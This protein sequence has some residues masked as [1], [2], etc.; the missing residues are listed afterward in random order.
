MHVC[1]Y[2]PY[3]FFFFFL[4]NVFYKTKI[5]YRIFFISYTSFS[6][7]ALLILWC[8]YWIT[9]IHKSRV[10]LFNSFLTLLPWMGQ[11]FF[12][13]LLTRSYGPVFTF[14]FWALAGKASN[15]NRAWWPIVLHVTSD[16]TLPTTSN[17]IPRVLKLL[18]ASL[19]WLCAI[20]QLRVLT[21]NVKHLLFIT[22]VTV[23]F[24]LS[25]YFKG[26]KELSVHRTFSFTEGLRQ[27]LVPTHQSAPRTEAASSSQ[28][29]S[30]WRH[31]RILTEPKS[32]LWLYGLR[33]YNCVSQMPFFQCKHTAAVLDCSFFF[34]PQPAVAWG[35]QNLLY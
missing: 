10:F 11:V 30:S 31:C 32:S 13:S 12:S 35:R 4:R 14:A 19:V 25:I 28:Q 2:M 23:I 15:G 21:T 20:G 33:R 7:C 17:Y 34:F 6:K 16:T 8:I 22:L 1:V 9:F 24:T 3:S 18:T 26:V 27:P 29:H 5:F